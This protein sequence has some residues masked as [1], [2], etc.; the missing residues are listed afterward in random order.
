MLFI[1]H[2]ILQNINRFKGI[3]IH[4]SG[5]LRECQTSENNVIDIFIIFI[6]LEGCYFIK[7]IFPSQ[8]HCPCPEITILGS[9]S[10]PGN[11]GLV[12]NLVSEWRRP[13]RIWRRWG[14]FDF[15]SYLLIDFSFSFPQFP[16]IKHTF[17]NAKMQKDY[18]QWSSQNSW[19]KIIIAGHNITHGVSKRK[20]F[21]KCLS[22]ILLFSLSTL[23]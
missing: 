4:W 11:I 18:Q 10:V 20:V 9:G 12:K 8:I 1:L 17:I 2:P 6:D 15:N 21:Y 3:F 14:E 13:A 16:T 19:F 22:F 5:G 7:F 23:N